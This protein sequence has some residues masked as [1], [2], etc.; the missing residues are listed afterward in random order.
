[1]ERQ[2]GGREWPG[3][4]VGSLHDAVDAAARIAGL[5]TDY[6][7]SWYEP[8]VSPIEQFMLDITSGVMAK[9]QAPAALEAVAQRTFIQELLDDLSVLASRDGRF[10][11]AAHCLCRIH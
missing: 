5:G 10:T 4:R 6:G 3:G 7:V 9:I 1:M 2:P 11:I 8:E